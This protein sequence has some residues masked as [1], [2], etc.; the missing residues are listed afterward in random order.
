MGGVLILWHVPISD[1]RMHHQCN[2]RLF[3]VD[4]G[5]Y[6]NR[7][8]NHRWCGGT[9]ARHLVLAITD[10]MDWR[11]GYCILYHRHSTISSRRE[12]KSVCRRGYGPHQGQDAP[13]TIYHCQVDLEYLRYTDH[14]LRTIVLCCRHEL[15]WGLKL[16][17]DN[18]SDGR[19]CH[20]QRK[21]RV[22]PL[23][24]YR[25]H[26]DYLPIPFGHKLYLA[27]YKHRK[28]EVEGVV[29]KF[30]I[31]ALYKRCD[32]SHAMDYVPAFDAHELWYGARLPL[33]TIPG[34]IIYNNHRYV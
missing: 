29:Y 3:W 17:D 23:A 32:W 8:I 1:T 4:I 30:R 11:I 18:N 27:I 7:C 26:F 28:D 34:G 33:C 24:N 5:L 22:L 13:Q 14:C 25:L 15:V 20:T 31:K 10:T 6:Y 2:W 16:L 12:R 21:H 9:A 19:F